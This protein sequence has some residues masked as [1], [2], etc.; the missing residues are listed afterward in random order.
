MIIAIIT[1]LVIA[2][3]VLIAVYLVGKTVYS[4]DKKNTKFLYSRQSWAYFESYLIQLSVV[5]C[6]ALVFFV[7]VWSLYAVFG[8]STKQV[9]VS[10]IILVIVGGIGLGSASSY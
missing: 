3:G 8:F 1:V 4:D 7:G 9:V 5:I 10:V 6:L 2:L